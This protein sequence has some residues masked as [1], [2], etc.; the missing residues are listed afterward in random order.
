MADSSAGH[1]LRDGGRVPGG[2]AIVAV[3]QAAAAVGL[4]WWR[5]RQRRKRRDSVLRLCGRAGPGGVGLIVELY[6]VAVDA[7]LDTHS[8]GPAFEVTDHFSGE[9]LA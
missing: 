9:V 5:R 1:R 3:V 8:F 4:G 2:R 6:G 7:V